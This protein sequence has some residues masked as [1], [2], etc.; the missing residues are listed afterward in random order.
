MHPKERGAVMIVIDFGTLGLQKGLQRC[1]GLGQQ[2]KL[3]S[4]GC[5]QFSGGPIGRDVCR[6]YPAQ[7]QGT[8]P[9]SLVSKR[10][11][12]ICRQNAKLAA[13]KVLLLCH[14]T[15]C[16]AKNINL[17]IS[18]LSCLYYNNLDLFI[19]YNALGISRYFIS[20]KSNIIIHNIKIKF[21]RK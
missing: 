17:G 7:R 12:H 1:W 11:G 15:S 16:K 4:Q 21:L 2:S 18:T 19:L 13:T 10:S 5:R 8:L 20:N 6:I 9:S 3:S 14:L